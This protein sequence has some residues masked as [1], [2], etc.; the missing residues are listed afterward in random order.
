ME[1]HT[2]YFAKESRK[3]RTHPHGCGLPAQTMRTHPHGCGL[4]AL[5]MSTHT[6]IPAPAKSTRKRNKS[7]QVPA[8]R[9]TKIKYPFTNTTQLRYQ[10]KVAQRILATYTFTHQCIK[11]VPTTFPF[12]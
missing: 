10:L 6:R 2:A 4:P 11:N 5:T 8:Q 1:H 7:I 9:D 12:P 3:P